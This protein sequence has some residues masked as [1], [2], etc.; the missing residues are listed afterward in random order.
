MAHQIET[1]ARKRELVYKI[2][3]CFSQWMRQIHTIILKGKQIR[4]DPP[5]VGPLNELEYW[6][7]ILATYTSVHEF[8]ITKPFLYHFK[9]LQLS[10]SKL[11]LVRN[12]LS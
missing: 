10:R 1:T 2:E 9:C 11:V 4:R 12:S 7:Q 6:R 8:I 5:D 3:K